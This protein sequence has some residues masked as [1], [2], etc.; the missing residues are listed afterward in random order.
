M[1]RKP[2]IS[3]IQELRKEVGFGC[4]ICGNPYLYWHHFDPPWHEKQHH[5]P[6][7]MIALCAVHH[8]K[9]DA[10]AYTK[11]QLHEFKR[12]AI[13]E[14]DEIKSRFDWMRNDILAVVGGNFYYK[15][16]IILQYKNKPCTWFNRDENGYLLLNIRML[17]ISKKPRIHIEDNVWIS[18]GN[19]IDLECPPS[20]KRLKVVYDNGDSLEIE[21]IELKALESA[22][23]RYPGSANM[24]SSISFPITAVEVCEVVGG[25]DIQFGP[26][27]TTIRGINLKNCMVENCRVA[28]N[29]N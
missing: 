2:P 26:K 18:R 15:T 8:D 1:H 17:T 25:T 16:Q 13:R 10:G 24:L 22:E 11:E 4:P 3:V 9:A 28:L 7:G 27:G 12:K 14:S 5:N 6:E 21:Y 29:I 23:S 19:P 20:G